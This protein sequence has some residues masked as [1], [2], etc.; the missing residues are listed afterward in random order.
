M[1]KSKFH[2]DE[3][4]EKKMSKIQANLKN[5]SI[6]NAKMNNSKI[7]RIENEIMQKVKAQEQIKEGH[8]N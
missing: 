3:Y 5:S 8:I 1:K 7:A 6:M 4:L 2:D